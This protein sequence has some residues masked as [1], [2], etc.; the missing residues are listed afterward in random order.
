MTVSFF[1]FGMKHES[2]CDGGG[3]Q[4]EEPEALK[5]YNHTNTTV[6]V[7]VGKGIYMCDLSTTGMTNTIIIIARWM[8]SVQK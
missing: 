5:R 1:F 6:H 4:E 8:Y 2:L 7:C 3:L